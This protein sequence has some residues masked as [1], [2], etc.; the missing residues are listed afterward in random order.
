MLNKLHKRLQDIVLNKGWK[1]LTEI[2]EVAFDVI[3]SGE[4]CV[5]EAPTSGGKTEA[6]FFPLITRVTADRNPGFKVL[7]IAPLKALLNDI[8]L[9]ANE[10][11]RACSI[12]SFKWHGDVSQT[13][14]V[15]QTLEP[16]EFLL[17][18]PE[19]LEAILLRKSSWPELFT[20]LQAVVIDEAHYFALTERGS[21]LISL[22]ERLDHGIGS[23]PQ[24]I[25]VTATIGNPDELLTWL[26]GKNR[27]GGQKVIVKSKTQKDKDFKVSFFNGEDDEEL[28]H[29]A[30]VNEALYQLLLN[31]KS[32]VFRNSR[33]HTEETAKYISERNAENKFSKPLHVLTH[34]SSVSKDLREM[35]ET[36]IKMKSESSLNAI[37]STSTLELG[38][39]IGELDQVIQVGASTSAG[40][41]L[42]R[43]GR[44]GRRAEKPQVFRGLCSDPDDLLLL[45]AC[46]NLGLKGQSENILFPTKA[47][48]ILAHQVICLCLQSNGVMPDHAWSILSNAYCF[49]GISKDEFDKLIDY[50]V[51]ED[52]LRYVDHGQ[53]YTSTRTEE[54]FLKMNW[55]RLFA[56]FDT[57][58]MYNVVDGKKIIGTLDSNFV[59]PQEVPFIFFLGGIEWKAF[60]VNHETQQVSVTKYTGGSIPKWKVLKNYDIPFE[61]AQEVG[62]ILTGNEQPP[63]LNAPGLICLEKRREQRGKIGWSPGSW[64]YEHTGPGESDLWTFA[65]DKINRTIAELI[66]KA[67]IAEC[68]SDYMSVTVDG[69][70]K[71]LEEIM[72]DLLK[73]FQHLS[74]SN[75]QELE[76]AIAGEVKPVFFSKFSVCLPEWLGSLALVDKGWDVGGFLREVRKGINRLEG[77]EHLS[78]IE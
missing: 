59:R 18:T 1:G 51:S 45:S 4:N 40:S 22:L 57:G 72:K 54:L 9:R 61:V 76:E 49:S 26:M 55:R 11:T 62:R 39:D 3:Y 69:R 5:I 43:V 34:H 28:I 7:Y 35:A 6:V 37:I 23:V 16:A 25:A 75:V 74:G 36:L 20:H 58:P 70:D 15:K 47:F 32:I 50:M 38:I 17:T 67:G 63:Y 14:K 10:Y 68:T 64:V 73:L 29:V 66:E 2:Q 12:R 24:R 46:I 30:K 13:D 8:E 78:S 48:H 21:H 31:K 53:L 44:T 77:R 19:S 56:V 41:F 27:T 60:K 42:Q 71:P 65:G 33:S 52:F